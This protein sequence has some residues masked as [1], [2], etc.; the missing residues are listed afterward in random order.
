MWTYLTTPTF[1]LGCLEEGM[2]GLRIGTRG[3]I[4]VSRLPRA[5]AVLYEDGTGKAATSSTTG[6]SNCPPE[7][8][9]A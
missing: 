1:C 7:E 5:T 9:M 3:R 6:T 8:V 2:E 4:G